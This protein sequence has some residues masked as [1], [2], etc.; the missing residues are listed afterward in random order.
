MV[1]CNTIRVVN[2][3][4]M[5]T[6]EPRFAGVEVTVNFE[7][8]TSIDDLADP[9]MSVVAFYKKSHNSLPRSQ[10]NLLDISEEPMAVSN[11]NI[12]E[13]SESNSSI[14]DLADPRM[15]VVAS[16]KKSQNS[17]PR[18]QTNL[19]DISEEPIA[20]S[21]TNIQETLPQ[22]ICVLQN[23]SEVEN[24]IASQNPLPI[25]Q[26]TSGDAEK[27]RQSIMVR[28]KSSF[29]LHTNVPLIEIRT[30]L[31]EVQSASEET[32]LVNNSPTQQRAQSQSVHK[33][34]SERNF[35][36]ASNLQPKSTKVEDTFLGYLEVQGFHG[37][38]NHYG[39]RYGCLH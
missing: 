19:V 26:D 25:K 34:N 8:S 15:S 35:K 27:N 1:F 36:L 29:F 10:T 7:N 20:E 11:I 22:D 6:E 38:W 13:N 30:S 23:T 21:N 9:R 18:S 32:A 17:L 3:I 12:H 2:K 24:A 16:Y 33:Q 31:G 37:L 14:D 28:S 4:I 39:A 5:S